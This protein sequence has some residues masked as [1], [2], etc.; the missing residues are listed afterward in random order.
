MIDTKRI[1]ELREN[2]RTG[3]LLVRGAG[4]DV[5]D[6]LALLAD[7]EAALP[8]LEA[9]MAMPTEDKASGRRRFVYTDLIISQ[10]LTYKE[11][12]GG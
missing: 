2:I 5:A 4:A 6:L 12:S 10:A 9:V 7:Y 3:H 8:L 1:A 11:R